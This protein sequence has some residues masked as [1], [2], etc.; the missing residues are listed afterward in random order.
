LRDEPVG[1]VRYV[2][3]EAA[4]LINVSVDQRADLYSLGVVLFECLAGHPPFRGDTVGE[5]LR[6][7]LN[8]EAPQLRS[9]GLAVP[10]TLDGLI[11]RMLSKAPEARYQSAESVLADVEELGSALAAGFDEPMI[12]LG[13]HDRR[14]I[15]TEPS[16][17]GRTQE[18]HTLSALLDRVASKHGGLVLVEAESGAGKT[19]LLD[20]LALQAGRRDIWVLRGQGVDQVAQQPFQVLDGVVSA[21]VSAESGTPPEERLLSRLGD[22]AEAAEAA[23]PALRGASAPIDQSTLG[24]EAY[25]E[26]RSINALTALLDLLGQGARPA[27]VLLDDCQWADALTLTLLAKWQ[28][29]AIRPGSCILTSSPDSGGLSLG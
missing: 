5:L 7:H 27:L 11:Q 3:P 28:S 18:L 13:L 29:M 23:L 21:I 1:T 26:T 16:F 15:L 17:V 12:T 19:R 24:P 8:S 25:G 14:H 6:Q 2:A 10:R 4:G 9:M 22:W 20:E